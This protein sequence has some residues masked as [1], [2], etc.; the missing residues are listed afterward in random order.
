MPSVMCTVS[1]GIFSPAIE[2]ASRLEKL[3]N[4]KRAIETPGRGVS[5]AGSISLAVSASASSDNSAGVSSAGGR[6]ALG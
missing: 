6:A 4:R 1:Q 2:Y 5:A 3:Q